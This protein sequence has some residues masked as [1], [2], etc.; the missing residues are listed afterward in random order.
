MMF[1]LNKWV[2]PWIYSSYDKF[3][4][5]GDI[6]VQEGDEC[7]DDFLD[8]FHA[9]NMVNDNSYKYLPVGTNTYR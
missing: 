3:L 7:L 1:S 6:N 2:L 8:E 9:R 5:A 4:I